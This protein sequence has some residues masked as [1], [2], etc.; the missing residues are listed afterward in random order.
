MVGNKLGIFVTPVVLIT[1]DYNQVVRV[2]LSVSL[3]KIDLYLRD[4]LKL[5]QVSL[6]RLIVLILAA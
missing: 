6:I 4:L 3:H 5:L 2:I 1:H